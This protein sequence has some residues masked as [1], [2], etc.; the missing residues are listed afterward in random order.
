MKRREFITL[1][2]G[3]AS[4][5]LAARAQQPAGRVYRVGYLTL[6]SREQSL[7]VVRVFDE[8]LR[9]LGYRVGENVA[10]EY[11]FA[12]GE[13]EQL[14]ALAA[15]L[16]RIGVDI[17][18]A[19]FNPITAAAMKAT[20]TIPIV[21]I[22]SIDPIGTGLIASLARPGG[23]VTGFSG[24]TGSEIFGKRLELMKEILPY[25]SR[26]GILF[27]PN[28][29]VSRSRLAS[30][31]ETARILGLTLVPVEAPGL[32]ALEQA[33]A[34]LVREHAQALVVQGDSVL[35]NCRGQIAEL[36]LGNRLPAASVLK[37]FA[38][39]GFLL[40]YGADLQDQFRRAASFVDRIL[41]GA[42]PGDLPVEQPIKFEL[43]INMKAAK[44]LGIIVPPTLLARADEV[45]E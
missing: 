36:A 1:L 26:V 22:N 21:M 44:A 9:K 7:P 4:L 13:M 24:D 17:I 30:M 19:T 25:L 12:D 16:V 41:K 5:P 6:A 18:L 8:G 15:D 29:A 3:A 45:I 42:K 40:G 34:K 38:E 31:G 32:D 28:V 33:F 11:R 39:A 14:P 2:G 35:F 10:I 23:N 20:T 37:E 43:V 27:N